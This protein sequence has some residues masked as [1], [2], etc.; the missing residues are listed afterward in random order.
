MTTLTQDTTDIALCPFK[1]VIDNREK[2][3]FHFTGLE[4]NKDKN[5]LPI[6]VETITDR[7]LETGDYSIDGLENEITIERKSKVDLYGSL[8]RN[9]DR[10][11][12]EFQR[13]QAMK[14][15]AIV[16]EADWEEVL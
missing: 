8:G 11:E 4:T 6:I 3:P 15:S 10:L 5:S 1:V 14:Y 12:R 13:M 9:R 2:A 7:H 16:L